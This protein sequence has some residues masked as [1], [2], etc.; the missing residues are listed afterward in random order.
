MLSGTF[1]TKAALFILQLCAMILSLIN[2]HKKSIIGVL[3]G[4][5]A[6]YLYYF[7]IGCSSGTCMIASNPWVA[8]PYFAFMG[9]LFTGLIKKK[10]E[11]R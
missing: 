8:V 6:G 11:A 10:N 5:L 7:F 1:I 3:I 2:R 4:A 9:Y